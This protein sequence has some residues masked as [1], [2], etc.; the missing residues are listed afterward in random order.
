MYMSTVRRRA[1]FT[2]IELL[3][4]IAIIAVLAG[5][6]LPALNGAKRRAQLT[7]CS[8]NLRQLALA[9]NFYS[10]DCAEYF[11]YNTPERGVNDAFPNWVGGFM[12]YETSVAARSILADSTNT[13]ILTD[14]RFGH[15][16]AYTPNPGIYRCPADR[17]YV[18]LEDGKHPRVRSYAMNGYVGTGWSDGSNPWWQFVLKTTDFKSSPSSIF[19]YVDEHEDSL[20]DGFFQAADPLVNEYFLGN[21]PAVHHGT[22]TPFAFC[23][24][25][26]E[27]KHWRDPRTLVPVRRGAWTRVTFDTPNLDCDWLFDHSTIRLK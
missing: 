27:A 3:V 10:S 1:A 14:R 11:P 26:V 2:L 18:V 15:L 6:L 19:S 24:G 13:S 5:L 20:V 8:N 17:S 22:S 23:D 16:G 25:H 12:S 4:S 21:A 7:Q 9:L